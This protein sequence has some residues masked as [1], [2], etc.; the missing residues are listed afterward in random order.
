MRTTT[1]S[2]KPIANR[3]T[4]TTQGLQEYLSC[5]R[6]AAVEVGTRAGARVNI[7]RRVLW[8]VGKIQRYLDTISE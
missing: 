5:G 8:N 6:A 3:A 7:G 1:K 4:V 2:T